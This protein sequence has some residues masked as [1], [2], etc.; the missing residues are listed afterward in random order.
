MVGEGRWDRGPS[1]SAE[2]SLSASLTCVCVF[3]S[4]LMPPSC[5]LVSLRCCEITP[6]T[7]RSLSLFQTIR[8]PFA[9]LDIIFIGFGG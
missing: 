7:R 4:L 1:L 8:G 9:K 3:T 2:W 5:L 6:I